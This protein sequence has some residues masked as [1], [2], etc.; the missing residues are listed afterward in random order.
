MLDGV[1]DFLDNKFKQKELECPFSNAYKESTYGTE[2]CLVMNLVRCRAEHIT[3]FLLIYYGQ[4]SGSTQVLDNIDSLNGTA[5]TYEY[6]VCLHLQLVPASLLHLSNPPVIRQVVN[7]NKRG[8]IDNK[9][10][11]VMN[12]GMMHSLEKYKEEVNES[13]IDCIDTYEHALFH[14]PCRNLSFENYFMLV[15]IKLKNW[16]QKPH[17]DNY[18]V[19]SSPSYETSQ[20]FFA[21]IQF[22][23]I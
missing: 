16:H 14:H 7:M 9:K 3:S 8:S 4:M 19:E 15:L 10:K 20:H 18:N 13:Y 1:I 5:Q 22:H 11:L 17:K 6:M 21:S 2:F 12:D 23:R